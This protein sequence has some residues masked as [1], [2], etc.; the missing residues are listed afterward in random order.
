MNILA[1]PTFF[2]F[3]SHVHDVRKKLIRSLHP[4]FILVCLSLYDMHCILRSHSQLALMRD[5]TSC[6]IDHC[7][8]MFRERREHG[9]TV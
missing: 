4:L 2:L 6:E 3:H 8:C 9:D 7:D 5:C 1:A